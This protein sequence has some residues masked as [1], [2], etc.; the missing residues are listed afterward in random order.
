MKNLIL[1]GF[2]ILITASCTKTQHRIVYKEPKA[3]IKPRKISHLDCVKDLLKMDVEAER[4]NEVCT[5]I[6]RKEYK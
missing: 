1:L 2:L 4:A 6:F 3:F 5:A